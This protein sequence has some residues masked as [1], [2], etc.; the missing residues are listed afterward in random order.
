MRNTYPENISEHSLDVSV[1]AHALAV[2]RNRRFGGNI[3]AE[4]CALLGVFHDVSEILT[5]DMPTPV[6]YHNPEIYKAYHNV[7]NVAKEKLLSM[8]PEDL[9]EEYRPVL[10]QQQ[11]E[12][13]LW[14]LV[15]AADKIAALIKCIEEERAGNKEFSRAAVA[16]RQTIMDMGV[17]EA[18]VFLEEFLPSYMLTLDEQDGGN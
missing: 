6:K 16:L 4:R 5:G 11:E 13:E 9:R 2:I 3:S 14:R 10:F 7:E 1:I 12:D 8:L 17:K 15:K 18:E